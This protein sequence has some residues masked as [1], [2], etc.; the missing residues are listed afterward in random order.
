MNLS[1]PHIIYF[2]GIGG[3]G[4]SALA[5]YFIRQGAE[6]HGYD[7]TVTTLTQQLENEGMHIHYHEDL[8]LIPST[9]SLV[10]YTPAIPTN[11]KELIHCQQ[12][13]IK[14]MKRSQVLGELT[15]NQFTI[16]VAGTHGKT[17]ITSTIA[18]MLR[19]A[20]S[21]F[22]AFIGG[23]SNNFNSNL[24]YQADSELMLVEA[25]EYD[26]SFLELKPDVAVIS[27][28]D[29]DHLDIYESYSNL[30]ESYESF[31]NGLA[32]NGCLVRNI[33]LNL[34]T[35]RQMIT[36]GFSDESDIHATNMVT[37]NNRF[38]F[39]LH[40]FNQCLPALEIGIPGKHN[41]ENALAAFAVLHYMGI[42][43]T[44]ASNSLSVYKGVKRRFDI[45]INTSDLVYIDD[46]AHHPEEI[47]AC[48]SAVRELY[49]GKRLTGIFQPHLYSRTRDLMMGFAE[50]LALLDELMLLDIYPARELPIPGVDSKAL[51]D[52]I[53]M[54][55]KYLC[56]NAQLFQMLGRQTPQ[57]LLTLGAGD[58]DKLVEP[59][60]K[61]LQQL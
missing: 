46:Y 11:N 18:H 23:I 12:A 14:L 36:Y 37:K 8:S 49:P 17:S 30:K 4:M 31:A 28:I 16:A 57:V 29:P 51:F 26:K 1:A 22:T 2:L 53:E 3:I 40:V 56:T 59:I 33:K 41:I 6:I 27:S 15:K 32:P 43:L 13:G 48:I 34:K 54:D 35:N 25:D 50:S 47:K 39:D 5:R 10:I 7:R 55:N 61:M 19:A 21:K 60:E 52:L 20:E 42:D 44:V 38:Y 9:T 58:I 45:R 24:V